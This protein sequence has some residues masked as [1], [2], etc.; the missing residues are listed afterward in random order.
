MGSKVEGAKKIISRPEVEVDVSNLL[1]RHALVYE[2]KFI[3][4]VELRPGEQARVFLGHFKPHDIPE[5]FSVMVSPETIEDEEVIQQI[6]KLEFQDGR[7][8]LI[9]HIANYSG[10]VVSAEVWKP[11]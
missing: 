2:G 4:E 6:T 3:E 1:I 8:E 11:S 5:G 7:Y 9:L 10:K